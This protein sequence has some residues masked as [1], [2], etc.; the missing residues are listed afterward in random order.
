MNQK[1]TIE[2]VHIVLRLSALATL[3][4]GVGTII[5]PP[6]IIEW[7]VGRGVEDVHFVRFIGTALT[8]FAV[9]NWLYSRVTPIKLALPAVYGN[10]TSLC[11]AIIID[12]V[13]LINGTLGRSVWAVLILHIVFALA[14][15]QCVV[16]IKRHPS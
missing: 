12:A 5:A 4:L 1:Q 9:T 2:A 11:L 6:H 7:F 14:F 13:G 16:L 10:L 3:L 8:G 15:M